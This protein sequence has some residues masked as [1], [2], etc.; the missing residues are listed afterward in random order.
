MKAAFYKNWKNFLFLHV[1]VGFSSISFLLYPF[2]IFATFAYK[3]EIWIF[4]VLLQR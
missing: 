1:I 3:G 4:T 2:M